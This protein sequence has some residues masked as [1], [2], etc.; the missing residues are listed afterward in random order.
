MSEAASGPVEDNASE[1]IVTEEQTP[2]A[3]S[4]DDA[5]ATALQDDQSNDEGED[6]EPVEGDATAEVKDQDGNEGEPEETAAEENAAE[7][8]GD[9]TE[10]E[11][12]EALSAPDHWP[13]DKREAFNGLPN[14]AKTMLLDQSKALEAQFTRKNQELSEQTRFAETVRREIEPFADDM[15]LSGLDEAGAIRQLVGLHAFAKKDPAGY[16]NYVANAF[17]VN[18]ASLNQQPEDHEYIDPQVAA[19]TNKV[20]SLE[21]VA[22]QQQYHAQMAQREQAQSMINS[23]A[24]EADENGQP[25]RPHF[26]QV[27]PKMGVLLQ[28]G[29]AKDMADAYEQAVWAD[30]TIRTQ[31][32]AAQEARIAQEAE[33]KRKAAVEK[34]K[35]AGKTPNS[36]APPKTEFNSKD[37]DSVLNAAIQT[38]SA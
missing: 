12:D 7:E 20:H 13:A 27:K 37:L 33:A 5:L 16:I 24:S 34:A 1:E 2:E 28:S 8:A 36:S 14:E 21:S 29:Q 38:H 4:L 31:M 3:M 32:T 23:F 10:G 6:A 30:P 19:L 17:G 18:L 35:R 25:L 26:E 15:R 22:Q 9:E 11:P